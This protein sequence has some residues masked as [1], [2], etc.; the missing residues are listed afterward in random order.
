M[1][2]SAVTI[3]EFTNRVF[4]SNYSL[5]AISAASP[6]SGAAFVFL[7]LFGGI[8]SYCGV[9]IAQYVGAGRS[10][11]VGAMLWQGIYVTLFA[12]VVL[13][14]IALFLSGPIFTLAGHGTEIQRLETLYFRILCSGGVF[15][16]A[17]Q[18]LSSFS[19]AEG[20]PDR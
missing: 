9:F 18:T 15:Y 10:K 17:S 7:V 1:G 11:H 2:M 3:M 19:T 14:F 12:G 16:V 6:A 4:L 5:E 13:I 8:G 20:S